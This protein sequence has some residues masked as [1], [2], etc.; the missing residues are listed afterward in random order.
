[1]REAGFNRAG[2]QYHDKKILKGE[3]R[4]VKKHNN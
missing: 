3:H 1:M 4:K 2:V